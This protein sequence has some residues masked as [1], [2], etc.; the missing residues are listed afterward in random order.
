MKD[1][2]EWI[3][4]AGMV[5]TLLFVVFI[6]VSLFIV[7]FLAC[8]NPLDS[9]IAQDNFKLTKTNYGVKSGFK[10]Q[11]PL[12]LSAGPYFHNQCMCN[13]ILGMCMCQ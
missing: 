11:I 4:E 8:L 7:C 9:H 6:F 2:K 5:G 12:Y 1:E 10:T 3:Y 13:C